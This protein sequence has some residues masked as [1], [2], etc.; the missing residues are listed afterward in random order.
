M[1]KLV[2]KNFTGMPTLNPDKIALMKGWYYDAVSN[3]GVAG[4]S[5]HEAA[6]WGGVTDGLSS[7]LGAL[8]STTKKASPEV[9][10]EVKTVV[11]SAGKSHAKLKVGLV[12][13]VVWILI[14]GRLPQKI[15]EI[16][17]EE[18]TEERLHDTRDVIVG[19]TKDVKDKVSDKVDDV[20][21]VVKDKTDALKKAT[22]ENIGKIKDIGKD[23]E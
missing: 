7:C 21:E 16:W 23:D 9:V 6:Y 1:S 2:P 19:T 12:V 22:D 14:D 13:A 18:V 20:K 11:Q 17:N 5:S 15:K 10:K 4:Q 3:V 8:Y